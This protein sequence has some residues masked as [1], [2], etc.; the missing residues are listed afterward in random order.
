MCLC[1]WCVRI[2]CA[3]IIPGKHAGSYFK[4]R[5]PVQLWGPGSGWQMPHGG[6][7]ETEVVRERGR[8]DALTGTASRDQAELGWGSPWSPGRRG[9]A[10]S[11]G[12][13]ELSSPQRPSGGVSCRRGEGHAWGLSSAC[14]ALARAARSASSAKKKASGRG[15]GLPAVQLRGCSFLP[16]ERKS[17]AQATG[18]GDFTHDL[19]PQ[20]HGLGAI[21]EA[22]L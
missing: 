3:R 21:K 9:L 12:G 22:Y 4:D 11:W 1:L 13:L 7:R 19:S 14:W 6:P 17:G 18:W 20:A 15:G 2:L 10:V 8:E 16:A 5:L